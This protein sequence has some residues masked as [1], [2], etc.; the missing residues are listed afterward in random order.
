MLWVIPAQHGLAEPTV[1][2]GREPVEGFPVG[3]STGTFCGRERSPRLSASQNLRP[4]TIPDRDDVRSGPDLI[5][6][7]SSV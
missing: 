1:C 5:G 6:V 4:E 2:E 7:D 3:L